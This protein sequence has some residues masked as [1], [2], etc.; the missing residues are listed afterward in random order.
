MSRR[1]KVLKKMISNGGAP[2]RLCK[3][4]G[5][6]LSKYNRGNACHSHFAEGM[7]RTRTGT[8]GVGILG[9]TRWNGPRGAF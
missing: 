4:C 8:F 5:G 6:T 9:S 7:V 2:K 1:D 3:K